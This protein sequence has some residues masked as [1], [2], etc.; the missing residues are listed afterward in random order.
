LQNID[1]LNLIQAPVNE[2]PQKIREI[3]PD[4]L[5]LLH[6]SGV[7]NKDRNSDMQ[8][9][10]ILEFTNI[11]KAAIAANISK[12]IGIGS[13]AELGPINK[14]ISDF[15]GDNPTTVYGLSKIACRKL[16]FE[17]CENTKTKFIWA[18]VIS[19]YGPLD[20][21]S[22]LI[23]SAILKLNSSQEFQTTRGEQQWSYLHAFDFTRALEKLIESELPQNI[24]NVGNTVT[25]NLKD[26][27]YEIEKR[28]GKTNLIKFGVLPYRDDQV[29]ILDPICEGLLE[30]GWNPIVPLDEGLTQTINWF[31]KKSEEPLRTTLN[32][33]EFFNLPN[34]K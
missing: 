8:K 18:R 25:I 21:P 3:K 19:T 27:L 31:T 1:N 15:Q 11:Y 14:P 12:I 4:I 2:W 26:L 6:W 23:P 20:S 17:F 13:Q 5:V 32:S 9:L 33:L 16:G 34:M 28:L 30:L 22:W 24:F 7:E 10:N 29:M